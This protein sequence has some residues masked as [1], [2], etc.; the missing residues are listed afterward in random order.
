MRELLHKITGIEVS[1]TA[2]LFA[3]VYRDT[4][5]LLCHDDQIED[6]KIAF[7]VYLVSDDWNEKDG[8]ALNIYGNYNPNVD[9]GS[10]NSDN[11][12]SGNSNNSNDDISSSVK[13]YANFP[14]NKPL[15]QL[16]PKRNSVVLF[17]VSNKSYHAVAEVLSENKSRIAIGGWFHDINQTPNKSLIPK[18]E[19]LINWKQVKMI[20]INNKEKM[21][22]DCLKYVCNES[23][24]LSKWINTSYLNE[25]AILSIQR[26]FAQESS[27]NL[28]NFLKPQ[29][30]YQLLDSLCKTSQWK[31]V[32]PC[33][34]RLY[35]QLCD[36]S[37]TIEKS[38]ESKDN[39][40]NEEDTKI[41]EKKCDNS[42]ETINSFNKLLGSQ[43]WQLYLQLITNIDIESEY[44]Q[45]WRKF[46]SGHY[47]IAHDLNRLKNMNEALD[48]EFLMLTD[49]SF[50]WS[51]E[52][53]GGTSYYM[54]TSEEL[55]AESMVN[56]K[57]NLN[58]SMIEKENTD[59]DSKT[60]KLNGDNGN[61]EDEEEEDNDVDVDDDDDDDDDEEEE[62]DDDILL[63]IECVPNT[64]SLVYRSEPGVVS[65]VKY[66]N[67][68]APCDRIDWIQSWKVKETT[69]DEQEID[70]KQ[71]EKEKEKEK[72]KQKNNDS[73]NG[74]QPPPKKK[75]RLST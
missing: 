47:T 23:K 21:N 64:L 59:N 12:N 65:F 27:I 20:N 22:N 35:F 15:L 19:P 25:S 70:D 43:D 63:K 71:N 39:N 44:C 52:Q 37:N 50:G 34:R 74:D 49:E 66:L 75:A 57:Q 48:V 42:L 13:Q 55:N 29:E 17:E 9:S 32:G 51:N 4:N 10:S 67:H 31:L 7:I 3:S 60:N 5:Y 30:Y 40:D 24:L 16:I 53:C 69:A 45:E 36:K 38:K 26:K 61:D 11:S 58:E 54:M 56:G 33:H 2:D 41:S 8:G 1:N 68:Y 62:E 18:P 72:D 6:R 14:S 46:S 73:E 28:C